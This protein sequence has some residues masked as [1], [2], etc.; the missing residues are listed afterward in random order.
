[1]A[2]FFPPAPLLTADNP[3]HK[4]PTPVNNLP[5]LQL[6]LIHQVVYAMSPHKASSPDGIPAC[7]Y[8]QTINLLA[9]HL[10]PI[11][12]TSLYLGIYPTEWQKSSENQ[13]NKTMGLPSSTNLSPY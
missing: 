13:A 6:S 3:A 7:V 4:H 2:S 5:K 9:V 10:L 8:I 11:F 12:H 1:M